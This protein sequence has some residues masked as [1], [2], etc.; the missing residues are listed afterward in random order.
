[1][2]VHN[3]VLNFYVYVYVLGRCFSAMNTTAEQKTQNNKIII[4]KI[5]HL[6]NKHHHQLHKSNKK[7]SKCFVS[8][9]WHRI[10]VRA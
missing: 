1:M 10:V 2:Q 5:I 9:N 7:Y 4:P 3:I 6:T 8:C